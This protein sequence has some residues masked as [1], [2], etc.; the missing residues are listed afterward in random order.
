MCQ[1]RAEGGRRCAA[2]TRPRFIRALAAI[3]TPGGQVAF[4][5]AAIE[6]ATTPS[7]RGDVEALS[8]GRDVRTKIRVE[9]ILREAT[10]RVD[11]RRSIEEAV[12][13]QRAL[14]VAATP[15][16][17]GAWRHDAVAT[18]TRDRRLVQMALNNRRSP[19]IQAA[20]RDGMVSQVMAST[21][22][23]QQSVYFTWLS[24]EGRHAFDRDVLEQFW[25]KTNGH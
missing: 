1:S 8:E 19:F 2:H 7:G 15:A 14:A 9:S 25:A 4:D 12:Q 11:E 16:N 17:F 20:Q 13:R 10:R 24:E 6:H 3:D 18:L 22:D 5:E 21:G 23:P